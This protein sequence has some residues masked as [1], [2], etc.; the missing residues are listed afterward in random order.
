MKVQQFIE[1]LRSNEKVNDLQVG[2]HKFYDGKIG[3]T[4]NHN[5]Y[6]WFHILGDDVFFDHAYHCNSGRVS[7]MMTRNWTAL[8]KCGY[9]DRS[10]FI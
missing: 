1:K 3:F 2:G 6:Y 9:I 4:F 7:R 8:E 5:T 10:S